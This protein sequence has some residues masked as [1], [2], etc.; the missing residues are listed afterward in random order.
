MKKQKC[1]ICRCRSTRTQML[2]HIPFCEKDR[3]FQSYLKLPNDK[4]NELVRRHEK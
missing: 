2:T 3:C 1:C 4:Q